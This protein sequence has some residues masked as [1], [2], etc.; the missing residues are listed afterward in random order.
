MIIG[1]GI[2]MNT[3]TKTLDPFWK[4]AEE[5][6]LNYICFKSIDLENQI[7]SLD[8]KTLSSVI[9]SLQASETISTNQANE[10]RK[11]FLSFA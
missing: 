8:K 9:I 3:E 4:S 2:I 10:L 5:L 11:T 1:G 6:I 7:Q